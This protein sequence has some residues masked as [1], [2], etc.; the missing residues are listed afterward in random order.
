[1]QK[2]IAP[3]GHEEAVE[4]NDPRVVAYDAIQKAIRQ[5]AESQYKAAGKPKRK[6]G[7]PAFVATGD[8]VRAL[9]KASS[10]VLGGIITP[11]QAMALVLDGDVLNARFKK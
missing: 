5:I 1:M 4:D 8:E 7:Q 10:D 6:T 9:V 11:E 3:N 2:I